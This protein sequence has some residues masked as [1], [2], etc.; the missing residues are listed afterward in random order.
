LGVKLPFIRAEHSKD[1]EKVAVKVENKVITKIED[2]QIRRT[3]CILALCGWKIC[4][5][6]EDTMQDFYCTR[7]VGCW[8]FVSIQ[9]EEDILETQR[10]AQEFEK[11][12][13]DPRSLVPEGKEYFNPIT[14]H[15]SWH[16]L[17]QKRDGVPGWRFVLT[18]LSRTVSEDPRDV[19]TKRDPLKAIKKVRDILDQR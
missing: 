12:V 7:K 15:L 3:S 13:E 4:S 1:W 18:Q 14:E 10:V 6:V 9:D 8:S 11:P 2:P 19:K 5:G 16:P 17:V